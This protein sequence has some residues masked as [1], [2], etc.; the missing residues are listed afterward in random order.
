MIKFKIIKYL[1]RIKFYM[2]IKS[3]STKTITLGAVLTALIMVLQILG[4]PIRFG[5]FSVTLV[6]L[7]IVVG[8]ATCGVIVGT[9]LGFVFGVAV[10]ISG[11][12]SAFFAV[13][14][15]G[16]IITVLV[17]GTLCGFCAA[18]VYNLL[19]KRSRLIAVL[20]AAI[21]CP[22]VNTGVF[23]LGCSL[24][25]METISEWGAAAGFENTTQYMILGLVGINFLFEIGTNLVLNP[26]IVR[27]LDITNKK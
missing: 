6:L 3:M 14:P 2:N 1:E 23:L 27:I 25:F 18:I 26:V 5:V 20:A 12:A 11:D 10:L 8:A 7:P 22:I 13:N 4:A 19:E 17:K 24:F 21:V 16:T 9:W 15:A